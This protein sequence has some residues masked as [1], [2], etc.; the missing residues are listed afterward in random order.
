[1][2]RRV[3]ALGYPGTKPVCFGHTRVGTGV[4]REYT[5]NCALL[6]TPQED[7]AGTNNSPGRHA[8]ASTSIPVAKLPRQWVL[9]M[10]DGNFV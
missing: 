8:L 2:F 7:C 5:S 3:H 6:G 1:M 4:P 9:V 10:K